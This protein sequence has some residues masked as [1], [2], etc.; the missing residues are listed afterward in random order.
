MLCNGFTATPGLYQCYTTIIVQPPVLYCSVCKTV[1]GTHFVR[2]SLSIVN[3]HI[4]III[5]L[6]VT[7]ITELIVLICTWKSQAFS[8]VPSCMVKKPCYL[9]HLKFLIWIANSSE[10][11][12][13]A[14][15]V[16]AKKWKLDEDF[17]GTWGNGQKFN[18]GRNSS[19][20]NVV[21]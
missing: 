21:Q 7:G 2:D 9:N 15:V 1:D 17:T 13:T 16:G 3:K 14:R 10:T 5:A 19:R 8:C 20:I 11:E 12:V 18:V 6:W 4:W